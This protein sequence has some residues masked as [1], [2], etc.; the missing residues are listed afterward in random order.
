M[1]CITCA[2]KKADAYQNKDIMRVP[3]MNCSDIMIYDGNIRKF[4]SSDWEEK[5]KIILC[6]ESISQDELEYIKKDINPDI[7]TFILTSKPINLIIDKINYNGIE[8]WSS[9]LFCSRLGI[10]LNGRSRK[11]NVI[12][13]ENGEMAVSQM[14]FNSQFDLTYLYSQIQG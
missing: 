11:S 2:K 7:K 13:L 1:G 12:I 9:Y 14:L 8:I 4:R 6:V 10:M 3:P 5:D